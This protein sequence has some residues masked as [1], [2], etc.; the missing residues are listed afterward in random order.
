M[1]GRWF[2]RWLF[3]RPDRLAGRFRPAAKPDPTRGTVDATLDGLR[4]RPGG[5]D[6]NPPLIPWSSIQEVFAFSEGDTLRVGLRTGPNVTDVTLIDERMRG[7]LDVLDLLPRRFRF[8]EPFWA[9]GHYLPAEPMAMTFV[10]GTP[11]VTAS[12]YQKTP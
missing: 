7:F 3:G 8:V 11:L 1:F 6:R 5:G 4:V 10:A 9:E 12:A 2:L